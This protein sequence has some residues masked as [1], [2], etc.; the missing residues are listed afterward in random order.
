MTKKILE[1]TELKPTER[2]I[3][4]DHPGNAEPIGIRVNIISINDERMV[5]L[6]RKFTDERLLLERRGKS[7]KAEHIEENRNSLCFAAMTGWE[8]YGDITYQGS[9]PEFNRKS[10]DEVLTDFPWF[11]DQI[12]E[13]I[14]DDKAF[15]TI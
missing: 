3:E 9:K 2:V 6:K 14:S 5:R 8:W 4:I 11:R 13:A 1:L 10:C 12:E 15:F 7:F